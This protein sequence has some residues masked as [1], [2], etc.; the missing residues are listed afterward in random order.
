MKKQ[1]QSYHPAGSISG[2]A[3]PKSVNEIMIRYEE[4]PCCLGSQ[5]MV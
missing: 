3:T 1:L 5:L 4:P 2:V